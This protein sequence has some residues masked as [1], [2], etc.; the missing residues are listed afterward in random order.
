MSDFETWT[1][2][3]TE[4]LA[5]TARRTEDWAEQT[6]QEAVDTADSLAAELEKQLAPTLEQWADDLN[7]SIE[8]WETAV[9]EEV[10]RFSE[11]FT[12]F[13]NPLVEPLAIALE[14]WIEAI[15]APIASHVDPMINDHPT[16]IGCKHYYGQAHGGN[17]LVCA[18]Y[19]YG[20]EEESCADWESF[21]QT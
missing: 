9:D 7:Q 10:E 6:L 16:C 17:M 19:P 5:A 15:S 20:P 14:T 8:P 13:L 3:L 2:E 21:G 1:R 11:E 18:M 12:E 4:F